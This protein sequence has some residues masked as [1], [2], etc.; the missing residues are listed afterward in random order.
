MT[1]ARSQHRR[2]ALRTLFAAASLAAALG[3]AACDDPAADVCVVDGVSHPVGSTFPSSDGCNTCSCGADGLVACTA[4]A[5]VTSCQYDGHTYAIGAQFPA[6]DGCNTCTCEASGLASC[7]ERACTCDPSA[8]WWR[9]YIT[10]TA[11]ECT[12][13]LFECPAHTEVFS[14]TCGCGCEQDASC[15]RVIACAPPGCDPAAARESCPYSQVDA[16]AKCSA[17]TPCPSDGTM[18]FA[19]G[20]SIGCGICMDPPE[21]TTCDGDASCGDGQICEP[22]ACSCS[23][24]STCVAGCDAAT[25]CGLGRACATGAHPR[26]EAVTCD[27]THACPADFDCASG[28]CARRACTA[29]A[30]CDGT[31][32]KGQ[33][34]ATPGFCSYLPP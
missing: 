32:V 26:C 15:A 5:C 17:E 10:T 11:S 25:D 20:E 4:R 9:S 31:C 34:Y 30:T 8:E 23:G 33:C 2:S 24:L 21:G 29:S 1:K 6:T 22:V 13:R 27:A 19:P 28:R 3:L 7:T 12:V 18:C 14:N 16:T